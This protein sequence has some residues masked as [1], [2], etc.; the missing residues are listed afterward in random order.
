MISNYDKKSLDICVNV[1]NIR[2]RGG[3]Y[4]TLGLLPP[5]K[6]LPFEE[7]NSL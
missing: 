6:N 1:Y 4:D 7:R 2:E 5:D 3:P